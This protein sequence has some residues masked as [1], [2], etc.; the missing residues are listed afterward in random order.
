VRANPAFSQKALTRISAGTPA[1]VHL[2]VHAAETCL[3]TRYLPHRIAIQMK[4]QTP[5]DL[6]VFNLIFNLSA[7][8]GEIAGNAEGARSITG[9]DLVRHYYRQHAGLDARAD[10]QPYGEMLRPSCL[11]RAERRSVAESRQSATPRRA[12]PAH[13]GRNP[14]LT[15][16]AG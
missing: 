14:S 2:S 6:S 11:T 13:R 16:P 15:Q 5:A 9:A 1:H 10:S 4:S 12:L 8:D 7:R 3:S